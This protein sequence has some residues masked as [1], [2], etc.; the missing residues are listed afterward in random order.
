M[1]RV[2]AAHTARG[3]EGRLQRSAINGRFSKDL[4]TRLASQLY[5]IE[6]GIEDV[7]SG[8]PTE[9]VLAVQ[10]V[11]EASDDAAA[12]AGWSKRLID[13]YRRL[14]SRRYMQIQEMTDGAAASTLAVISGFGV[15]RIL[16][17]EAGLHVLED[18]GAR[19]QPARP[20][21][22][23]RFA[24]TPDDLPET[25]AAGRGVLMAA[26][27]QA[28]A[29]ASVVRRYRLDAAPLIRDVARGWRTGRAE[30]VMEGQVDLRA[31][32]ARRM[33]PPASMSQPCD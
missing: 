17:Q 24:S 3:L 5:I 13:M 26:L 7:T 23:V 25:A 22:R 1:D 18:T 11:L 27:N 32:A 33:R 14:A 19:E 31:R 6:H 29:S 16:S 8:A 20:V 2:K 15:A 4:I 10:P 30:I 9:I 12:S 21:A 28:P